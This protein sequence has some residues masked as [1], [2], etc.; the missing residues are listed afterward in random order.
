MDYIKFFF[1]NKIP[2]NKRIVC[3]K[4]SIKP[5]YNNIR[6]LNCLKRIKHYNFLA[7][8][9]EYVIMFYILLQKLKKELLYISISIIFYKI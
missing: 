4:S 1:S 8:T 6:Q 9:F 7:F 2:R 3:T 5:Y